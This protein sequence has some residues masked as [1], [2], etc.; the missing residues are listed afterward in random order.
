[1]DLAE[2][3]RSVAEAQGPAA[4]A[5]G[6]A[7]AVSADRPVETNADRAS[8]RAVMENLVD[9]AVRYTARGS[10]EVRCYS[11][12]NEAV[13]EVEDTGSGIPAEERERVFGRFYRSD[14]AAE[15]GGSG[16]GLAIVR[17]IAERHGGHVELL[18]SPRGTGLLVRVSI[19]LAP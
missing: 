8:L 1:V 12:V 16:L 14:S 9:N 4:Q 15:G 18:D 10:V 11:G 19:P 3:A 17:R 5:K 6:L 13:F 2:I 7:L